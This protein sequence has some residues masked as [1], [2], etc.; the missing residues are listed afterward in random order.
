MSEDYIGKHTG[1]II[2]NGFYDK[3]RYTSQY[4]IPGAGTFYFALA[5]IWNLAYGEEVV[6]SLAALGVFV[7][8]FIGY[9]KVKYEKSDERFDG[10]INIIERPD[11]SKLFSLD[12]NK[13]PE[14]LEKQNE[15]HFKI[16]K[17]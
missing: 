14:S 7:G 6:G 8:L 15:A 17:N 4:V 2:S 13:E 16:Q 9:S 5:K 11:A 12:L 3:L 10:E 1:P